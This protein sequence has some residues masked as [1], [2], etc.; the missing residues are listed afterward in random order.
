MRSF[1]SR[2]HRAG[3]LKS[4]LTRSLLALVAAAWLGTFQGSAF[5]Q[6]KKI[7]RLAWS[8]DP[9]TMDPAIWATYPDQY[10]ME[11]VYPR[12]AKPIAGRAWEFEMDLA[13]SVDFSDPLA[14]K[15]ELKPG[16]MW[17][18]G[19]GEVTAE[20]VKFSYE[21]FLSPEMRDSTAFAA[22]KGVEITGKY[23]GIIHLKEPAAP[24]WMS[25]LTY[26]IGS[27]LSKNAYEAAGNTVPIDSRATSGAYRIKEHIRGERMVL[28]KDPQWK[29]EQG[30]YDE[31]WLLPIEDE[32]AA[33]AAFAAGELDWMQLSF[34]NAEAAAKN[35]VEGGSVDF[36]NTIDFIF[37]GISMTHLSDIRVRHAIQKGIDISEVVEAV[38][39][40]AIEPATGIAALGMVGYRIAPAPERDVE[41][42]RKLLAEAGA[43][44]LTVHFN[45][46]NYTWAMTAAQ[47]MQA[48]LAEIGVNVELLAKDDATF[49]DLNT[50]TP[51]DREVSLQVWSGNPSAVYG[52]QYFTK[53][54]F[55][56]WNWQ[57]F[58]DD[59]YMELLGKVWGETDDDKRA[60]MYERM[61]EIMVES[62]AFV[63]VANPPAGYLI[64]DTVEAGMLA[65]GRPVFHAF[66]LAK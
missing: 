20:D 14:I 57:H 30:D 64:R 15:F 4:A 27:I 62:G 19:Y 2:A 25:D 56:A 66:K 52:L 6:D 53:D 42:A 41:G 3:M 18:G 46:P 63:F 33:M 38:W 48:Q 29:G 51:E 35:G 58:H 43:E 16:R 47:V 5:A 23:S 54:E 36:R 10:L 13:S 24:M 26:L 45:L 49:F 50:A 59:E 31:I 1:H 32:N 40:D 17:N 65:D 60:E 55:A 22:L 28:E 44:G 9:T 37:L 11:N 61:Q 12:L 34:Q 8:G 21:R 39:G 7:V